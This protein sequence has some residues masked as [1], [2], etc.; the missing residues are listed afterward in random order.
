MYIS[1]C[2][3]LSEI[4]RIVIGGDLGTKDTVAKRYLH[5]G[6]QVER[7][8]NSS[9]EAIKHYLK[10]GFEPAT[11]VQ[12]SKVIL[13]ARNT[14]KPRKQYR[15]KRRVPAAAQVPKQSDKLYLSDGVD[16]PKDK[17]VLSIQLV[18]K[19]QK[20]EQQNVD[21][22]AFFDGFENQIHLRILQI[23]RVVE[24][25]YTRGIDIGLITFKESLNIVFKNPSQVPD[26]KAAATL[27]VESGIDIDFL[28]GVLLDPLSNNPN[29]N[30]NPFTS[31]TNTSDLCL[32]TSDMEDF[33]TDQNSSALYRSV[34]SDY[35]SS[36]TSSVPDVDTPAL[37][38]AE[39]NNFIS[40][41][42][43]GCSKS[44]AFVPYRPNALALFC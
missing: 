31:T 38:S 43:R 26:T 36:L 19:E 37:D 27:L 12:H 25:L 4:L 10:K 7:V 24:V 2:G 23:K 44:P 40:L 20:K 14:P 5:S 39:L 13:E 33:D 21:M 34:E 17:I 32:N 15:V 1:M 18:V 29:P 41:V 42:D 30:S 3:G 9:Q 16:V 22:D 11:K 35:C 6:N 8:N 28:G